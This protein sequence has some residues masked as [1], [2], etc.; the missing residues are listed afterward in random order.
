[1]QMQ[2]SSFNATEGSYNLSESAPKKEI[3]NQVFGD[4]M[5]TPPRM[6]G[7]FTSA[8]VL[9]IAVIGPDDPRRN[10]VIEALAGCPN[11][12]I[13]QLI[14][15]PAHLDEASRVRMRNCD[16][17]IVELDS[18]PR[19][20]L[21]LVMDVCAQGSAIV[22]VYSTQGDPD[23]VV[24]CMRAGV[25]EF[26][27]LPF[28]RGAMAEALDR[29]L[30]RRPVTQALQKAD[31][32][33]FVFLGAKGGAG[34]TTLACNFA[35]SLAQESAKNT[36]LIDLNLP[37]GDAAINL[38]IKAQY[39][40]VDALQNSIRLDPSL[41]STMLV[42]YSAW[43]SVLAAPTEL[44]PYEAS[45]EAVDRLLAVARQGFDY[46]V[47]D[48]GLRLDLQRTALFNQ[49]STI[50]LITQVGIPELR[51]ANRLIAQFSH[52]GSPKLEVVINRYEAGSQGIPD[53]QVVKALTRP[54]QWRIPNNY[55]A[56]R[57]MQNTATP[58]ALEDS[59]ISRAIRQM[60]KAACGKSNIPEK[61]KGFSFFR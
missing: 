24:R 16:V 8:G 29:T 53:A 44:T 3:P 11:N 35:V 7:A 46:V 1:M 6:P 15:D 27:R 10:A 30:A 19:F 17:V 22:M 54:A 36:L 60:V 41:L 9:S 20:A 38:G 13:P 21:D 31:G 49:F 56:V 59:T 39:S 40:A 25:R 43:L 14:A 34:V 57:K 47:V 51:N 52:E 37:L 45:N 5:S 23:L 18:D 33:L 50:Y 4:Y 58:L 2:C 48:A 61:K 55:A 26:L 42:R 32:D 28:T 12:P